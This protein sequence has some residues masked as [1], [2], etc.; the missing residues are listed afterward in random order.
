MK[1]KNFFNSFI[2][3]KPLLPL[4]TEF[5]YTVKKVIIFPGP[6]QD[7]TNQ[8]LPGRELLNYFRPGRVWLV[9]GILAEGWEKI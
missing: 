4:G 9:S 8:A 1:E 6:S 7:A 2:F 5:L 3:L